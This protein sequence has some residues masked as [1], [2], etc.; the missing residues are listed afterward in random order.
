MA[1][2]D[3][4]ALEPQPVGVTRVTTTGGWPPKKA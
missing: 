2:G 1:D 4:G 3:W